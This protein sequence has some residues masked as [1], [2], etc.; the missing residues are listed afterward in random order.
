MAIE[1][2]IGIQVTEK[3]T[4]KA[5]KNVEKLNTSLNKVKKTTGEVGSVMRDSG[6]AIL[7]N[8]GAMGLLNDLTGGL[9]MTVKDAVEATALFTGGTTIATGAQKIYTMVVGSTTGALKALRIALVST[10]LGAI[11]VLL[12]VF[13]SKMMESAEATEEQK[14]QQELLNEV[15][16][17]TNQLYKD[18]IKDL[19]DVTNERLLRAKI[20]GKSEKEL[21]AIELEGRKQRTE[22]YKLEQKR[23]YALLD[24]KKLTAE[25]TKTINDQL[26]QNQ[27]DYFAALDADKIKDLESELAVIEAKRQANKDALQK[28]E[29]DRQKA[30]EEAEKKRKEFEE[31]VRQG[32]IDLQIATNEAEFEQHRLKIEEAERVQAELQ[33][34]AEEQTRIEE[35]ENQKR[36]LFTQITEKAKL[37]ATNN[38][39]NLLTALSKKGSALAKAV[40]IAD[41]V[42]GQVSSVS[43]IISNTAEANAKAVALSPLTSGQPFVTLN[44]VS[45]GL[46]IAAS[47]AGAIKAIKDINSETQSASGGGSNFGA[48]GTSA[49]SFNLVQGTGTNQIAEGLANQRRPLQA[50]VVSGAVRTADALER[51]IINDASL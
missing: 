15:L 17:Q 16:K 26:L 32:Q 31:S 25:Q 22:D 24:D 37:D 44:T 43:K 33:R 10:G 19:Q 9:A 35:E 27:K 38:A 23:L 49:P 18:S 7:E 47:V 50:Y 5:L 46:G 36:L 1:K 21:R 14:R 20:A 42:R 6:N 3:G 34:I 39:F 8:G 41:V 45:A 12:G 48:V 30:R 29:E 28:L 2:V 51:N 13:I 4:E 40:A 11:V